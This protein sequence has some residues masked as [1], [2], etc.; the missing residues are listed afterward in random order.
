MTKNRGWLIGSVACAYVR[1][2]EQEGAKPAAAGY[3]FVAAAGSRYAILDC[4]CLIRE[5]GVISLGSSNASIACAAVCNCERH[6]PNSVYN[7]QGYR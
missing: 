7:P 5:T 3:Y 1:L 4:A 2:T 6:H